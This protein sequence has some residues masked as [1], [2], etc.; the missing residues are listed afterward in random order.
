MMIEFLQ[1]LSGGVLVGA[2]YAS[3]ALGLYLV[4]RV[5]GVINLAQGAFC[6]LGALSAYTLE[7]T[8]GWSAA[9]AAAVAVLVTT[10][11]GLLIGVTSFLPGLNRLPNG[12]M[13]MLTA[14]LL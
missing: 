4:F 12:G 14:G 9:S 1:I 11:V 8:F 5:T 10:A 3:V 2:T 13:L 7:T 6:I